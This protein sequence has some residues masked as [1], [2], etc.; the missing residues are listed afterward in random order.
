M[1]ATLEEI[2]AEL[3][4]SLQLMITGTATGGAVGT[5]IDTNALGHIEDDDA[6]IGGIA[7]IRETTDGLAPEGESRRITDYAQAT[8]TVTVEYNFTAAPGAGDEY[9]IYLMPLTLAEWDAAINRAIRDAWP[10]VFSR[11]Y[12]SYQV[13]ETGQYSLPNTADA[14]RRVTVHT[15]G[16]RLGVPSQEIPRQRWEVE[17]TP[18]ADLTLR[19]MLRLAAGLNRRLQVFYAAR[20]QPLAAEGETDLDLSYLMPR[21]RY[22]IHQLLATRGAPSDRNYHLQMMGHEADQAQQAKA[23]LQADLMSVPFTAGGKDK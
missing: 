7:Y 11:E 3:A 4:Q 12:K 13:N 9:E 21:A 8:N 15:I 18:G 6:L 22:H 10:E 5:I 14:V 17:G 20:Y 23:A 19:L 1:S 2:R 16:T